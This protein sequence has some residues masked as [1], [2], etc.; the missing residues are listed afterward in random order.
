M[1]T[2]LD[3]EG[4]LHEIVSCTTPGVADRSDTGPGTVAYKMYV[5]EIYNQHSS[6]SCSVITV[7]SAY[8]YGPVPLALIAAT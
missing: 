8:A 7:S 6:P 3:S 5:Y 1:M 2:P 4:G